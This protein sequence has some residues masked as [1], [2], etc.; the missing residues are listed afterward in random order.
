MQYLNTYKVEFD[1][2]GLLVLVSSLTNIPKMV[3]SSSHTNNSS[4]NS[5]QD[6]SIHFR[7]KVL[8]KDSFNS[9]ESNTFSNLFATF[10]KNTIC[11]VQ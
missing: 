6:F 9:P 3:I 8:F 10:N 4:S 7:D 1:D 5:V 2:L 11:N